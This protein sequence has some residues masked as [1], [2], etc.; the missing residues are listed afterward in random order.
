[1]MFIIRAGAIGEGLN[2][3]RGLI[4]IVAPSL[5][6]QERELDE[7]SWEAGAIVRNKAFA[8]SCFSGEAEQKAHVHEACTEMYLVQEGELHIAFRESQGKPWE[9]ETLRKGDIMVIP[10]K[11]PHLVKQG[12]EHV[13]VVLQVPA[14]QGDQRLLDAHEAQLALRA[15]YQ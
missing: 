13:T 6:E 15:F 11:C 10:P 1:M 5:R 12:G 4:K 3:P 2:T 9:M 8:L 14:S 7:R